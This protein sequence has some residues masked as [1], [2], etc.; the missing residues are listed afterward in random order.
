MRHSCCPEEVGNLLKEDCNRRRTEGLW[1]TTK[2]ETKGELT[3]PREWWAGFVQVTEGD[4][5]VGERHRRRTGY[6]IEILG[7]LSRGR[8][9]RLNML[10]WDC[11]HYIANRSGGEKAYILYSFKIVQF[12]FYYKLY[13]HLARYTTKFN[14]GLWRIR[15]LSLS[16]SY[17]S[18]WCAFHTSP[19]T[20]MI[21]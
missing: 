10:T 9:P 14:S 15:Y 8:K 20:C 7:I 19:R 6:V 5:W 21:L 12:H 3:Q 17:V 2:G 16:S 18:V 11:P 4:K 13:K 1:E